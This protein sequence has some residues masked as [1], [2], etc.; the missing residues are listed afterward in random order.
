[1]TLSTKLL[2]KSFYFSR[3]TGILLISILIFSYPVAHKTIPCAGDPGGGDAPNDSENAFEIS[4]GVNYSGN[5]GDGDEA[6]FY[7]VSISDGDRVLIHA[8]K[9]TESDRLSLY[10]YSDITVY[11]YQLTPI[12]SLELERTFNHNGFVIFSLNCSES[13]T[14]IEYDF[15]VTLTSQDD[16][17]L[18][19]DA[20]DSFSN[21]TLLSGKPVSIPGTIG[22]E[23][24][25]DAYKIT[26]SQL[27]LINFSITFSEAID[28]LQLKL[29]DSL[30][31]LRKAK[32]ITNGSLV[33]YI[34]DQPFFV[35]LLEMEGDDFGNYTIEATIQESN[36]G[37][38][39]GDA[40][41]EMNEA[42][43][44]NSNQ[45]YSGFIG[46]FDTKDFYK[47]EINQTSFV[48]MIVTPHSNSSEIRWQ[49]GLFYTNGTIANSTSYLGGGEIIKLNL[50][51]H[52]QE[53]RFLFLL[54][55]IDNMAIDAEQYSLAVTTNLV[56]IDTEITTQTSDSGDDSDWIV[57]VIV[58]IIIVGSLLI[59]GII[60]ALAR[61]FKKRD[62]QKKDKDN[63]SNFNE[64]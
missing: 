52:P 18:G 19:I 20:G 44:I 42:V 43:Q 48:Q 11:Q 22:N 15:I 37:N 23:D 56:S 29:Y 3:I 49:I 6:D 53:D 1:M 60:V 16:A 59:A 8:E 58:P 41:G 31:T 30:G 14:I 26:T 47:I 54:I 32:E 2:K 61:K 40:G 21:S 51:F 17:G 46:N 55:Q 5:V 62:I 36:D 33:Q 7:K 35:L 9:K 25:R 64:T 38:S 13:A 10:L 45:T 24:K 57:K 27:I 4:T 34:F 50:L 28:N 12:G 39:G 63:H